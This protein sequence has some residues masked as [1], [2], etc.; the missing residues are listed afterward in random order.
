MVALG[1]APEVWGGINFSN[2]MDHLPMVWAEHTDLFF[3]S[4]GKFMKILLTDLRVF[5]RR[6]FRKY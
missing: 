4:Q 1:R 2:A 3:K 5:E 6:N